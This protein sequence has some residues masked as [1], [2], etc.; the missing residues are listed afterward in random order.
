MRT[1]MPMHGVWVT[2]FRA[3]SHRICGVF[4]GG[5]KADRIRVLD[6]L[7]QEREQILSELPGGAH[8]GM[9]GTPDRP[10]YAL[11]APLED[12][13]SD[14]ACRDWLASQLNAFINVLRPR[15]KEMSAD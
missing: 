9:D 14:E 1:P 8:E 3:K 13:E 12:F 4:L 11:Y 6:A 10:G 5:R 2:A 15:L 7:N